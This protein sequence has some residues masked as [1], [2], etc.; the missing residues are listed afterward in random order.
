MIIFSS[1]KTL[2]GSDF[3]HNRIFINILFFQVFSGF[4]GNLLLLFIMIKDCR[5]ILSANIIT[6]SIERCWIV[7]M[8]ENI[9]DFFKRYD[10]GI[11][12]YLDRFC[13]TRVTRAYL[14]I[15]GFFNIPPVY[16]GKIYL[17]PL[18]FLK[19]A[20]VHQKHPFASVAILVLLFIYFGN[21][22]SF[23][24]KRIDNELTHSL[25][26]LCVKCSPINSCPKCA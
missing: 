21:S 7:G 9:K 2:K 25:L 11:K 19:I 6:L 22:S 12:F 16:P 18:I 8:P 13:M 20:S 4:L 5:T 23:G 17:M 24:I 14:F 1:I 26:F 15:E 3:S 10:L